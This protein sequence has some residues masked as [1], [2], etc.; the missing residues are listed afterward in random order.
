MEYI[1]QDGLDKVFSWHT[2]HTT[3]MMCP[4]QFT[5]SLKDEREMDDEN[6]QETDAD[7]LK[8]DLI[9]VCSYTSTNKAN[10]LNHLYF[11]LK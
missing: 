10:H 11:E 8:R 3:P 2:G 6:P 9:L 5:T 7:V 4:S 1:F